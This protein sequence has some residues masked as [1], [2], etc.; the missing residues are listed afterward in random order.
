MSRRFCPTRSML[1]RLF[2]SIFLVIAPLA[3]SAIAPD[4]WDAIPDTGLETTGIEALDEFDPDTVDRASQIG[5]RRSP[6]A[7]LSI[8]VN[9]AAAGSANQW[10]RQDMSGI[11]R[12]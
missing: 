10:L 3:S 12:L 5:D 11:F 4:A 2:V 9:A 1:F 7:C 6:S 8:G